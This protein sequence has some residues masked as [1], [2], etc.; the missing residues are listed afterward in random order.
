MKNTQKKAF[1]LIELLV[2]IAIIAILAAMLLPALAA[3][4]KKAQKISCTN[5]IKQVGLAFKIWAGDNG[6]RYPM[7]VSTSAG[8]ASEYVYNSVTAP[9]KG[10]NPI[11]PFMVM[12]NEL[13]TPKVVYCPSDTYHQSPGTN[14]NYT[15]F[16]GVSGNAT[17]PGA[18]TVIGAVSYF[19]NG[20]GSDS[21]PQ[22]VVSGDENIGSVASTTAPA[23]AMF[24]GVSTTA[25]PGNAGTGV[26]K[27]SCA[28]LTS[29]AWNA[30]AAWSWT[31]NETHQK[32]GN[33]LMG[34]G[35]AQ[36][37]SIGGLHLALQNSTNTITLQYFNFPF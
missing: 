19:V 20:N 23:S 18:Q 32:S 15:S 34:D 6:D 25:A 21:D 27:L 5:N 36:S 9:A 11:M 8:G 2:V 35:S 12:S 26:S 28:T 10:H 4:K 33:V 24:G 17:A 14:F 22:L 7:A 13:S 3:A 1:T 37:L 29:A 31:Q 16:A 30:A